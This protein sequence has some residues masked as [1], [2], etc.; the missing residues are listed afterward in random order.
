MYANPIKYALTINPTVYTSCIEQFWATVKAIT[1][2]G[3]GQ[4][5]ALIDGK[6]VVIT[7]SSIRRDLQLKDAEGLA[8]PT[9]PYHTPIFIQ[10]SKSQ[11]QKT[12]QHRKPR[13]N[14]TEVPQPSDPISVV[15]KAIN[16]VMDDSLERAITTATSLD[17]E[18]DREKII[19]VIL[20][21]DRCPRRK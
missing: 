17:A 14:I 15:D 13:R 12:N 6:K 18:Q 5:Q 10:P 21:R 8:N 2:N 19:V 4:L 16:E 9:D 11:P 1:V 7:E 3:E 20:V